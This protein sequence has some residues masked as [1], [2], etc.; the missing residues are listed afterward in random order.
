VVSRGLAIGIG[1]VAA[2]GLSALAAWALLRPSGGGSGSGGC[3]VGTYPAGVG[4]CC[5]LG[6]LAAEAGGACPEGYIPDPSAPGC[7]MTACP[8]SCSADSDCAACGSGFVCEGGQCAKQVPAYLTVLQGPTA[9]IPSTF[10]YV[11]TCCVYVTEQI[12]K[13][14]QGTWSSG[15]PVLIVAQVTDAFGRGV[16]GIALN[17]QST[18]VAGGGAFS[19]AVTNGGVTDSNGQVT[20][21]LAALSAPGALGNSDDTAYPCSICSTSGGDTGQAT[22]QYGSLEISAPG[23]P[24]LGTLPVAVF[25]IVNYSGAAHEVGGCSCT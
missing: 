25:G 9:S 13:K 4:V 15:T 3:P 6:D 1:V 21:T 17:F 11:E 19:A 14:C 10:H 16:P 18:L 5:P 22:D 23:F 7:C 2:A 20:I 8:P 24:G 12:C